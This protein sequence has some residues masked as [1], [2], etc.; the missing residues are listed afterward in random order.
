MGT[1]A[2][3]T[4]G[5]DFNALDGEPDLVANEM[6]RLRTLV[7]ERVGGATPAQPVPEA[8]RPETHAKERIP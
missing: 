7:E 4:N 8:R 1:I 6:E 3:S 5:V 2:R